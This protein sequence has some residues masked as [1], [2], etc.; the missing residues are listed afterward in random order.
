[1]EKKKNKPRIQEAQKVS[2]RINSR[3]TH[4]NTYN[5]TVE[6]EESNLSQIKAPPK[7][8]SYFIRNHG[9]DSG[10]I[11]SKWC[12]KKSINYFIS[13]KTSLRIIEGIPNQ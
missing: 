9:S 6:R 11:N 4:T 10:T 13:N 5:Q 1:M 3:K 8:N 12:R 2:N 7:I